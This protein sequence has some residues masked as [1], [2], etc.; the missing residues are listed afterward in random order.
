MQTFSGA[1]ASVSLLRR[2][3]SKGFTFLALFLSWAEVLVLFF[4][5]SSNTLKS[6]GMVGCCIFAEPSLFVSQLA[7]GYSALFLHFSI[8]LL[9]SSCASWLMLFMTIVAMRTSFTFM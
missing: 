1:S 6:K 9:M 2:S 7:P 4:S 8:S 3:L 5:L